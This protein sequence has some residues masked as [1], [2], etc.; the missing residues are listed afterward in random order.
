MVDI[1]CLQCD[2]YD[3]DFECVRPDGQEHACILSQ[4]MAMD[5]LRK[6][7]PC[8]AILTGHYYKCP[9]CGSIRSIRQKHDFCHDCGQALDWVN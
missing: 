2:F 4:D 5:A 1:R 6:Q 7:V 9:K 8:K 3:P